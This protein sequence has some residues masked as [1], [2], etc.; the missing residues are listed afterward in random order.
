MVETEPVLSREKCWLGAWYYGDDRTTS[1]T[2]HTVCP[3]QGSDAALTQYK[4]SDR[5]G[6]IFV[7]LGA[8]D[9]LPVTGQS[10]SS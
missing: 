3:F 7:N 2:P 9:P 1:G 5:P 8:W 10:Q 6:W 4:G